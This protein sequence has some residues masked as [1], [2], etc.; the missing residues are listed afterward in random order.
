MRAW[1]RARVPPL[2]G[3]QQVGASR[4]LV[5]LAPEPQPLRPRLGA[6]LEAALRPGAGEQLVERRP[7]GH[8]DQAG[9]ALGAAAGQQVAAQ[10]T[11]RHGVTDQPE[12]A[13]P[14]TRPRRGH[15][16]RAERDQV[17][18]EHDARDPQQLVGA[19]VDGIDRPGAEGGG[20]EAGRSEVGRSEVGQREVGLAAAGGSGREHAVG[21]PG[22]ARPRGQVD[23]AQQLELLGA[24]DR[25][26]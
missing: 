6:G 12:P 1:L 8:D 3:R 18:G 24:G 2:D 23:P 19:E 10:R 26:G 13:S 9:T 5:A 15:R 16:V 11:D 22:R 17:V 21:E 4:Q 25:T 14:R 7:D 20:V